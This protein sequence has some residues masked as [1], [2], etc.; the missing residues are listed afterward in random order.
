MFIDEYLLN[1]HEHL[2]FSLS[3]Q[4]RVD[5]LIK[6]MGG[7]ELID[8]QGEGT[9]NYLAAFMMFIIRDAITHIG[10]NPEKKKIEGREAQLCLFKEKYFVEKLSYLK[11]VLD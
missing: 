4:F 5:A 10:L 6:H 2:D 8:P 7:I 1:S 3:V 11:K 9:D